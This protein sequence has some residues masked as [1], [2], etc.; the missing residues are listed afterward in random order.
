MR[1]EILD[2]FQG[3][4]LLE[5]KAAEEGFLLG[6]FLDEVVFLLS[7]LSQLRFQ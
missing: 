1:A 2:F 5:L 7:N 4:G 3:R 6:K